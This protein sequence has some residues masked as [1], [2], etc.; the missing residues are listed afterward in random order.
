MPDT[1]SSLKSVLRVV[2]GLLASAVCSAGASRAG[3]AP[4]VARSVLDASGVKGGLVVHLGC[5]DGRLT[6]ALRASDAFLVHGLDADAANV[7][8]ARDHIRSLGL[9]GKVSV[10]HWPHARLPYADRLVNLLVAGDLGG[11]AMAEVMRVLAPGGAACIREGEGWRVVRKPWPK[12]IDDWSHYLHGPDNNAVAND[13]EVGPPRRTRWVCGPLWCGSHEFLSSLCAMVTA[14]GRLFYVFDFGLTGV[15]PKNLP[16]RWTLVARDAFNGVLLWK[17]QVPKWGTGGWKRGALRAIP[18]DVPRRLVAAGDRVF[19]T[20]GYGAP[21]SALDAATG[22]TVATYAETQGAQELRF[23]DGVLI[24]RTGAGALVATD[25]SSGETLWQRND[26]AR[27]VSFAARD[28]RVFYSS[29][30]LVRCVGLRDGKQLWQ[31]AA[32]VAPA[33]LVATAESLLVAGRKGT[34]ALSVEDGKVLWNGKAVLGGR[35]EVFVAGGKIWAW[36][37]SSV[38]GYDLATGKQAKAVD[39]SDVFTKGHHPRCYQAKATVR[40]LI[41]PNRGAEFVGIAGDPNVQNDWIRGP[42]RY[43]VMPGNGLFYAPPD[44][45]F[46]YP[47]VKVPGFNALAPLDGAEAP[48]A[49][50]PRLQRGPAYD[51]LGRAGGKSGAAGWPTY[52]HD[53]GRKGATA[54]EVPPSLAPAWRMALPAPLTAPVAA[55]GRVYVAAKDELTLYALDAGT[56]K[57]LWSFVAGGRIDSPPTVDGER[58]VFGCGDG[59]VYC[60]RAG[61]GALGWRF[62]AAPSDKLITAFGRLESPWRVHGSVL[63]L[64]GVAYCTAGRST[65]LDGGIRILALDVATGRLLHEATLDT[66]CRTRKDAVGK[67]FIPGYHAEGALSDVLVSDGRAIFMGQY[68]FDRQLRPLPC[69]YVMPGPEDRTETPKLAGQPYFVPDADAKADYEK[70]QRQWLERTQAG[71]VASL[72]ERFGGWSLG[73][74]L[75]GLHVLSTAGFLDDT[76]FNRTYWMYSKHWPGYYL[77]HRAPK[78]GELLVVGPRK[79]YAVQSYPTRNLQSPLFFPGTKGYLLL[80]DASD[81][82]PVLDHRTRQTTKGWGYMRKA[83]PVWFR[84]VPVRIRAMVLAGERLFAAGPP[85]VVRPDDPMAA[86]EGRAGAELRVFSAADGAELFKLKLPSPPVFDGLVA[87][88]GKLFMTTRDGHVVC[89]AG[90]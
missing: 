46:C 90:K 20:M 11:V 86:F 88:G 53:R 64:D 74:R 69:P 78:T 28:G 80:A 1:T 5:G 23:L 16:E 39:A 82:E 13:T 18:P 19:F 81:N 51:A 89:L 70:H 6:A 87:V 15:T 61:D 58:V 52:R 48:G 56:G 83:P 75:M 33:L 27:P 41:T 38:V 10:V 50:S 85:D 49:L 77:A 8:K 76:W 42:C 22:K 7:G 71:L 59:W 9:Y 31:A 44:P 37:A 65:Y 67:P 36:S 25:T 24:V 43:G 29:G 12:E 17:R 57:K 4:A 45:C 79:T 30:K 2:V 21:V 34:Q 55:G 72:R 63:L 73:Q 66:W 60:L 14:G 32:R 62:R 68:K 40:Y 47:G 54:A 26:G 35:G 3:G 84:W